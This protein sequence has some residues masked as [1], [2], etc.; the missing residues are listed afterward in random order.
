VTTQMQLAHCT[1]HTVAT[2]SARPTG[3]FAWR[4]RSGVDS[5]N[6]NQGQNVALVA[7]GFDQRTRANYPCWT[8][9]G[10]ARSAATDTA[11]FRA[12]HLAAP[13]RTA[14]A[15]AP[16]ADRSASEGSG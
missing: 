6:F 14:G 9:L 2:R 1:S 13:C 5:R 4:K 10:S 16:W 12:S 3:S 15:Y 7:P 11:N 8:T